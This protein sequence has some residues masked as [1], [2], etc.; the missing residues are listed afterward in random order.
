MNLE[1]TVTIVLNELSLELMKLEDDLE[2]AMNAE[3][4]MDM[5]VSSI[6]SILNQIVHKEAVLKRFTL[7]FADKITEK[8]TE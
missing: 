1:R 8:Q 2:R 7:M 6:K 3:I 4:Q 5:K